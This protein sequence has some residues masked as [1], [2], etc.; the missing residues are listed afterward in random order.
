MHA[1]SPDAA[2]APSSC[3]AAVAFAL[4]DVSVSLDRFAK[5][6]VWNRM[7]GLPLYFGAVHLFVF[8]WLRA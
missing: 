5:A 2:S 1:V 4:S 7:W 6:G 3:N 8:G